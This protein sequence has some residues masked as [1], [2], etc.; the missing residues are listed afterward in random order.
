MRQLAFEHLQN[1]LMLQKEVQG[2]LLK[3][4]IQQL[5]KLAKVSKVKKV[6]QKLICVVRKS[7]FDL[8]F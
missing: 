3:Q 7:Y 8:R 4:E 5:H 2:L 6:N 1:K